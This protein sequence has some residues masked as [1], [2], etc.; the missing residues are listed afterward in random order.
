MLPNERGLRLRAVVC[1]LALFAL[2]ACAPKENIQ[3]A[4]KAVGEFHRQLNAEAYAQIYQNADDELRASGTLE[5]FT[6]FVSPGR[7]KLG[8]F[9]SAE[10]DDYHVLYDL[11]GPGV[12]LFYSSQFANG[13]AK[14]AFYYK[15]R[16]G[17]ALLAGYRIDSPLLPANPK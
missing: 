6:K 11:G 2:T 3:L 7:L 14:E 9:Q 16:K 5:S 10:M 17:K 15:V 8:E 13:K 1:C 12:R 4:D